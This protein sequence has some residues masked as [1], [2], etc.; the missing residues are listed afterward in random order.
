MIEIDTHALIGKGLHR[1]CY[2][3]PDDPTLCIKV[4]VSGTIDE[5]RREAAYY[6]L[7]A[8]RD[9]SW[10]MLPKFHGLVQTSLGE[11]AVFDL[12]RDHDGRV[13]HTLAHYLASERLLAQYGPALKSALAELSAYLERNRIITM[14]L[15]PKNILFQQRA[16]GEGK[17]VIVDNIGN[18]D[19]IPLANHSRWLAQRK[20]RRKWRRFV[21]SM[22]RA[23]HDNEHIGELLNG[24][25]R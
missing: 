23:Y 8:R 22:Q 15:K 12:I 9:V 2:V 5:N 11:G 4:V 14:T 13:S 20:I 6:A 10:D 3:H 7:L 16:P 24:G 19:F 21:R 25:E 1:E 17:L 18:S